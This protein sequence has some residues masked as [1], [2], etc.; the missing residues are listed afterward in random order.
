MEGDRVLGSVP[1]GL[2]VGAREATYLV[3]TSKLRNILDI[4][5]DC[6]GTWKNEGSERSYYKIDEVLFF[7]FY[8]KDCGP[9]FFI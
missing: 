1:K 6:L 2:Q 5:V 9:S 8:C 7:Y 4:H 3:D